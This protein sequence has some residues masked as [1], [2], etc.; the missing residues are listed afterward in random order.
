M[1]WAAS[2]RSL[3]HPCVELRP[4]LTKELRNRDVV[5]GEIIDTIILLSPMMPVRSDENG[6]RQV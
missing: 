1:C 6:I 5:H 4:G 2:A 3:V